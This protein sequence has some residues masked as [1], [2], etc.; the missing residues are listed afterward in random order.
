LLDQVNTERAL[1][2]LSIPMVVSLEAD[3]VDRR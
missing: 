3:P 1:G 2:K